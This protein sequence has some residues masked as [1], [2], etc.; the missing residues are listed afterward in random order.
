[1]FLKKHISFLILFIILSISFAG[2]KNRED[3]SSSPV[4]PGGEDTT[5]SNVSSDDTVTSDVSSTEPTQ[6]SQ[7]SSVNSSKPSKPPVTSTAS[8]L[9][10]FKVER[11][12]PTCTE[13]G[14]TFYKCVECGETKI[15]SYV[16]K[17][18]HSWGEWKTV[19]EA[20]TASEGIRERTCTVCKEKETEQ[21]AMLA[22]DYDALQKEV[23]R[24]VN[25]ERVKVGLE[26]LVYRE[27]AQIC[28]DI[29][30][31]ELTEKFEHTRP[32]GDLCF[33]VLSEN[34][35]IYNTAGE[36]IASGQKNP[37][38]VMDSWMSSTEGHKEAIL[39]DTFK[40]I[41]IG[42]TVKNGVYYWVQIFL[43]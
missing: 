25:E 14:Y 21:I 18:G 34:N 26:P 30:A 33:T 5:H 23:F 38:A 29:R 3:Y 39:S 10:S 15:D 16:P 42:V 27:D 7:T 31:E 12:A 40:E 32:D 17:K 11:V 20:T 19:T 41:V 4:I 2:C 35:I 13:D 8:H 9:H 37:Q 28:A 22:P 6:S 24:L 1:M 36:N 43:S